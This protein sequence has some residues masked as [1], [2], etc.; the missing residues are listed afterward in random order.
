MSKSEETKKR[1]ILSLPQILI[2]I[3]AI[4]AL[5]LA[6]DL[7]AKAQAGREQ[8]TH[9]QGM[10]RLVEAEEERGRQLEVTLTYVYSDDYVADYAR[11][12]GGMIL[13]D[14]KRVVPM[15]HP[16]PL[17]PTPMPTPIPAAPVL[18]APWKAWWALF[19]DSPPPGM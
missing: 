6:L 18:D 7:N 1:P 14:E 5:G 10:A 15:P 17:T 16:L 19:F 12:E 11:D 2:I 4:V 3:G 9:E 8:T 13:P